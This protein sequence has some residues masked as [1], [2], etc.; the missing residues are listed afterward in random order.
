MA[1]N[2]NINFQY[3]AQGRLITNDDLLNKIIRGV[4][5][6]SGAVLAAAVPAV[7]FDDLP[8]EK[9]Y[10]ILLTLYPE[11]DEE[12]VRDWQIKIGRQETYDF[13]KDLVKNEAI[14]PNTSFIL[15]GADAFDVQF[16]KPNVELSGKPITVYR[17]LKVMSDDH[18]V[19]DDTSDF[20]IDE[21]DPGN[22][23]HGDATIM[24]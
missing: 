11:E 1:N 21:Y 6:D 9:I 19:L 3:D 12:T 24:E 10:L 4:E 5:Q 2:G 20:D 18:R 13:L 15:S 8:D 17:F 23:D 22:Y 7:T 14:D 16:N